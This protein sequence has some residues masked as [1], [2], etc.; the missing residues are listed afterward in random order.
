[1][2][3][4]GSPTKPDRLWSSVQVLKSSMHTVL[5]SAQFGLPDPPHCT[6]TGLQYM[7]N[8]DVVLRATSS[9]PPASDRAFRFYLDEIKS[10]VW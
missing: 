4:L 5:E 8:E 9:S 10:I 2:Y 1:M 7:S 3:V 6:I